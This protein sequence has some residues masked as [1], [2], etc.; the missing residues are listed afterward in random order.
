VTDPGPAR[1]LTEREIRQAAFAHM[2][3]RL[4]DLTHAPE[5]KMA[6]PYCDLCVAEL[7][8]DRIER[9]AARRRIMGLL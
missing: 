2:R 1:R 5:G 7:P 4:H 6:H 3:R 9:D 8:A